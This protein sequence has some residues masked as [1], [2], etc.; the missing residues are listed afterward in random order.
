IGQSRARSNSPERNRKAARFGNEN[1][2]MRRVVYARQN[3]QGRNARAGGRI[4]ERLERL[5]K[6]L[7]QDFPPFL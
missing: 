6:G 2:Q 7:T 3:S 1:V 5:V 4:T